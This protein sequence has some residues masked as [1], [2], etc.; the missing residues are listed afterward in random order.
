MRRVDLTPVAHA[1]RVLSRGA[2]LARRA[3]SPRPAPVSPPT[4]TQPGPRRR[5]ILFITIDQQRF[6][7]LGVNGGTFART[8]VRRRARARRAPLPARAR[9]ERRV[10][11]VARDDAHRAAPAHARRDRQRHPARRRRAERRAH[12]RERPGTAPRSS[13]RRTSIRTSIR[14]CASTRTGCAAERLDGPVARLRARRARDA[15]PARRSPLRGVAVGAPSR[16]ASPASAACSPAPAA[17]RPARPRSSTTRSRAST[18]TPTGS[19]TARSRGC[20]SLDRDEP[21]FCWMS[22]PDPHHPFDPPRD[23]V[24]SADRLARR[25]AARG[26]SRI[27]RARRAR[28]SRRSRATGSTGTRGAFRNPEGGP[29][30]FVPARLTHDQLR[31]IDRDDPRRERARSTRRSA[32]CSRAL[33]ERGLDERHRR[34]L[35]VRS[36]RAA[37]RSRPDVQGAVPRRRAAARA[38]RS[39]GRRRRA[40]V[41]PA[42]IDEPVGHVDL[43]PTFCA[44]AGVA[45]PAV[46]GGRSRCRLAPGSRRASG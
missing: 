13:A 31:E 21:F 12:L 25:A 3:L 42:A 38:D 40:A 28:C 34:L 36:R 27:A 1:I 39:G 15:R 23:E 6:D 22:F 10:H 37:G 35:H 2:F 11:A 4:Q 8:P 46:D 18:T 43:A 41:A 24:R 19:P 33:A 32:A 9:A 44:I 16:G 17:A 20:G 30:S 45:A 5:N 7:A 14:C 26:S 29:T